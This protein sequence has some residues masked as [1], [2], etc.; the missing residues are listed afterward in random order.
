MPTKYNLRTRTLNFAE[1]VIKFCQKCPK[2]WV[3]QVLINQLL[4]SATS[5]GANY[6][7]ADDAESKDDFIHKM[8]ICKKEA[9]EA[10]YWLELVSKF[11]PRHA[12][13]A[14]KLKN[15]A[16]ELN[17]ICNAIVRKTRG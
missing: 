7:E 12:T 16:K 9:R 10:E 15:E 13:E 17:L 4:R 5:I 3:T 6:C 2:T 14:I 1:A 11:V 8:S